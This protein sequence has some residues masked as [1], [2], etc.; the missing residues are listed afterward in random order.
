MS[1]IR[2]STP[3]FSSTWSPFNRL[4]S[5]HDEVSR[6][7]DASLPARDTNRLAGWTPALDLFDNK[8][9]LVVQVEVPGLKKEDVQL[10]LHDGVLTIRGERK[11][12][13]E[14]KS[15]GAFRSERFFGKFERSLALPMP[16]KSDAV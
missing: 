13:S 2:Y 3:S 5:L 1:L 16:V 12:E 8:E 14:S 4:A 9:S 11:H 15:G 6:L 10:E 7:F